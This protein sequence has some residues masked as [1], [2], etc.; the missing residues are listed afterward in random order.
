MNPWSH[1][2]RL[3]SSSPRFGIRSLWIRVFA[4]VSVLSGFANAEFSEEVVE[5]AKRASVQVFSVGPDG[6]GSGTGFVVGNGNHV[7]TNYHVVE[8]GGKFV[9]VYNRGE[10]VFVKEAVVAVSDS[11]RDLA[12]LKCVPLPQTESFV[13]ADRETAGGQEVMAVGFPGLLDEVYANRK[14]PGLQPTGRIDE[15]S[16][17]AQDIGKFAPV[18]FPGNVGKEM[19]LN[20]RSGGEFR[21]IAHSA[22]ISEGNSGGALIDKDGRVVGIN[23]SGIGNK[24]GVD[25]A[26]AI[27]VSELVALAGLHSI[28]IEITSTKV[29]SG[30]RNLQ[31][32][33][34][35][36]VATFALVIFVMVLRKPRTVM[37]DAVSRMV[38]SRRHGASQGARGHEHTATIPSRSPAAARGIMRLRG[39]DLQGRSYEISFGPGD[40]RHH[41]GRLVIGR[42]KDLSQLVV[43]H[44]SVSRQ[45]ATLSQSGASILVEDRNSGNGTKVNGREVTVGTPPVPLGPGDRLTL[46]EVDLIFEVIH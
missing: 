33:L 13:V 2:S 17:G 36:A 39:R 40:F 41:G 28:P 6:T 26:F 23:V 9:V 20:S 27:H 10:S 14:A 11:S 37:V 19:R 22:K 42:N 25:Y 34:W 4:V 46:G 32:V 44:D 31:I 7:V 1:I 15:F 45:H 24:T 18:T 43:A 21:A 30:G 16:I 35:V 12:I 38:G 5:H 29:S 3:L 8:G